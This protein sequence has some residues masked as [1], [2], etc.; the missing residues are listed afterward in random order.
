M[1]MCECLCVCMHVRVHIP[2]KQAA[3]PIPTTEAHFPH[4]YN[5]RKSGLSKILTPLLGG[6]GWVPGKLHGYL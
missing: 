2:G 3:L 1:N 4:S 6:V 5:D